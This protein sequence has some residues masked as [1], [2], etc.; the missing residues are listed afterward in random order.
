VLARLASL[1]A[2]TLAWPVLHL[3]VFWVRFGHLPRGGASEALVFVPM[4]LVAAVGVVLLWTR[5]TTRRQKTRL[6]CGYLAATPIAF[7]GSLLGGLVL[8]GVL[9]AIL[10]G[11]GP[12][13]VGSWIGY[14]IGREDGTA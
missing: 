2:L 4:G 1:V 6:V 9:G 13:L 14:C 12:L 7:L 5:A 8:P 11:A 10:Y 3:V